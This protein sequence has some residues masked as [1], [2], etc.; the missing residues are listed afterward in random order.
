V[1][2]GEGIG[3][4]KLGKDDNGTMDGSPQPVDV[5]IPEERT[6]LAT[7]GEVIQKTAVRLDWTLCDVCWT[8]RPPG[9]DLPYSMPDYDLWP[10]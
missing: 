5:G 1:R 6:S 10:S 8:I 7:N 2:S 4:T 9:P 3:H